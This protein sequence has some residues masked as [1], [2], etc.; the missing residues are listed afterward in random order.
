MKLFKM[1]MGLKTSKQTFLLK[2]RQSKIMTE[3][4][5]KENTNFNLK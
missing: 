2:D 5:A 4:Q 3:K 1:K